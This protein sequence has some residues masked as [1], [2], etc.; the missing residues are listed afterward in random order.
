MGVGGGWLSTEV[1]CR[2]AAGL[3]FVLQGESDGKQE[4]PGVYSYSGTLLAIISHDPA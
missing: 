3:L 4:R 2:A 1:R